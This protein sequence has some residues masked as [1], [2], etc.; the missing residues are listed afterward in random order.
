MSM[1]KFFLHHTLRESRELRETPVLSPL[2]LMAVMHW[3]QPDRAVLELPV[4]LRRSEPNSSASHL[5]Q[6][7]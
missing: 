3:L 2:A 5:G 6:L 4:L 1:A 7:S